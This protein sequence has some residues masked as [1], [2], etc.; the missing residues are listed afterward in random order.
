MRDYSKLNNKEVFN[1]YH[2]AK[3]MFEISGGNL[4]NQWQAEISF[5]KVEL[6]KRKVDLDG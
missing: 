1:K 2:Q 6:I 3:R 5:L 4:K